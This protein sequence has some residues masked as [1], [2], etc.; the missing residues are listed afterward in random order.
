[1]IKK[2]S[3]S[4][5]EFLKPVTLFRDD[6]DRIVEILQAASPKISIETDEYVFESVDDLVKTGQKIINNLV[7]TC[8]DI[9]TS[10]HLML[11]LKPHRIELF[12]R[13][14]EPLSRG[15]FEKI[16]DILI[17]RERIYA[18]FLHAGWVLFAFAI[19]L[20][21]LGIWYKNSPLS[22]FSFLFTLSGI[23]IMTWA[24]R[25]R[26]E[27]YSTIFLKKRAEQDSFWDRNKDQVLL[28]VISAV[29]GGL[30]TVAL[31]NLLASRP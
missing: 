24:R 18:R 30:I 11:F 27:R 7:I 6:L 31:T 23:L 4:R 5:T 28:A 21:I 19:A 1:M 2:K 20:P 16:K 25:D 29:V 22:A 26:F 15:L 9:L 3:P 13:E 14:D 12:A 8:G 10:P 17:K